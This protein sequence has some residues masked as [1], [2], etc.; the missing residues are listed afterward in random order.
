MKI[1]KLL[2]LEAVLSFLIKK[3]CNV[4][5]ISTS[6]SSFPPPSLPPPPHILLSTKGGGLLEGTF[7]KDKWLI[8]NVPYSP[9]IVVHAPAVY[10]TEAMVHAPKVSPK[11]TLFLLRKNRVVS[12]ISACHCRNPKFCFKFDIRFT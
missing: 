7:F 5:V 9:L 1:K 4:I 3:A 8:A 6:C 11:F 12:Y 10:E 2:V